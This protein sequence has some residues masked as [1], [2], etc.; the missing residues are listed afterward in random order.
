MQRVTELGQ[1]TGIDV[2]TRLQ[3]PRVAASGG[4]L[5]LLQQQ[6]AGQTAGTIKDGPTAGDVRNAE[7][8]PPAD[9]MAMIRGMVESLA[10]RLE[11]SPRDVEGWIKLIRSRKVLGETEAARQALQRAFAVFDGAPQEQT[12]L[13]AAGREAGLIK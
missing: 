12:R 3:R 13:D 5:G 11:Q 10:A 1:E 4:V 2:S 8:M 9:R 7:T 6:Q